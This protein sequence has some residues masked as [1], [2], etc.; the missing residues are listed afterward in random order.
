MERIWEVGGSLRNAALGRP[1][2]DI[3]YAAEYTREQFQAKFP[4]AKYTGK[5][6]PVFLYNG[7]E[8]ALTRTEESTGEK[9]TDFV[10]KEVGVPIHVDLSR[11]DFT[12]NSIAKNVVTGEII[13]PL[14]GY[15]DIQARVLRANFP[16]AFIES[17]VR[18][19][20]MARFAAE[21]EEFGFTIEPNTLQLAREAKHLLAVIDGDRVR[22]ELK[23]TYE[24][25]NR[26]SVF[27]RVLQQA[28]CLR[29]HFKPLHL[30]QFV[31]AGPVQYHGDNTVLDHLLESFD[32]AKQ[33]GHSFAV[34]LASLFHDTGKVLTPK[35]VLPHHYQHELRSGWINTQFV[36]Q[37]RF[38]ASEAELIVVAGKLHMDFHTLTKT[39]KYVKLIRFFQR[40]KRRADE[41][42]QVADN[43]HEL[44]PEQL[45]ILADLKRTF[46]ETEINIPKDVL[47]KGNDCVK[48]FVEQQYAQTYK[49]IRETR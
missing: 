1:A 45:K 13:D 16:A 18:V 7:D 10:V 31:P 14:G 36:K 41:L 4:E 21:L 5:S 22:A 20:R 27:F 17:S 28:D 44:S 15:A 8:Y 26:P 46:K 47:K 43:D 9:D 34:A 37:H 25:S 48:A 38:T 30:A 3:D 40:I 2:A 39:K 29:A 11:R 6:F 19:Y 24:R 12:I 23:K 42:I 33:K 49:R 35:S 32:R